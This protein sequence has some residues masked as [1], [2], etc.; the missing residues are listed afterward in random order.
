MFSFGFSLEPFATAFVVDVVPLLAS[1]LEPTSLLD[2]CR[3]MSVLEG[4]I[5]FC[6]FFSPDCRNVWF[7]LVEGR[8]EYVWGWF[9]AACCFLFFF[10]FGEFQGCWGYM[11]KPDGFFFPL[12]S[13]VGII[14]GEFQ[15]CWGYMEIPDPLGFQVGTLNPKP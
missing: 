15:G 8:N 13:Q 3:S 14:F 7:A 4:T 5:V 1:K 2:I 12:G 6:P 10:V 11:K 9:G